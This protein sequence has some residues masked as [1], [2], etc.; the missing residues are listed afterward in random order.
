MSAGPGPNYSLEAEIP[1]RL[2]MGGR[3]PTF[4]FLSAISLGVLSE[5]WLGKGVAS[6]WTS[7]PVWVSGI[8]CNGLLNYSGH[9][10][11]ILSGAPCLL[12]YLHC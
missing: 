8:P 3:N 12:E 2:D 7:T 4:E 6:T 1:A 9:T 11:S 5:N 10:S